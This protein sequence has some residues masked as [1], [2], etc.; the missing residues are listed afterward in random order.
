MAL[1]GDLKDF[2]LHDLF[3]LIQMSDR[4]G[5]LHLKCVEGK[6]VIFFKDGKVT[7]A[8]MGGSKGTDAINILLAWKEGTFSFNVD[9]ESSR[10]TIGQPVQNV[11][12]E[13]ARQIDEWKKMEDVLPSIDVVV[14]FVEEP[15]VRD[16]ELRP[17]EWKTLSFIDGEKSIKEIAGQ[18]DM[19]YF[20]VAKIMYGLVGSGLIKVLKERKEGK[21][22][23]EKDKD[24]DISR[25]RRFFR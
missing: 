11:I 22:G 16:I 25:K 17:G 21:R 2:E 4:D 5:A 24:K 10:V 19:E 14:D 7:H 6:G 8:E 15:D 9:E 12:L 13:A 1:H 20:D 18:L 3:Q 23:K